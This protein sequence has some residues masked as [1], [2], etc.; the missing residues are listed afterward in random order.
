VNAISALPAAV[1]AKLSP[2]TAQLLQAE[3]T[4]DTLQALVQRHQLPVD[5]AGFSHELLTQSGVELDKLLPAQES[6]F[7]RAYEGEDEYGSQG[8]IFFFWYAN[9]QRSRIRGMSWLLD[10]NPPWDGAAKDI[11]SYGQKSPTEMIDFAL[12]RWLDQGINLAEIDAV[13]AKRR[14]IETLQCNFEQ[15]IR[16]HRDF[17]EARQDFAEHVLSLPAGPDTPPFTLADY[18][19]LCRNGKRSEEINQFERTVG[20]VM[21][22]ED[23][24]A[25]FVD[26]SLIEDD[27]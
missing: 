18:D 27:R 4:L 26:A 9:R 5:A 21:R 17:Q 14:A 24:K 19:F 20:R 1:Q 22:M 16:L 13:T 15:K 7:Y 25:M 12:Q 8:L 11:M 2:I 3:E 23:G 10:F 6:T